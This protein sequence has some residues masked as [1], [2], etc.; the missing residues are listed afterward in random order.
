MKLTITFILIIFACS[1]LMS[2]ENFEQPDKLSLQDTVNLKNSTIL[3]TAPSN[4]ASRFEQFIKKENGTPLIMSTIETIC[5]PQSEKLDQLLKHPDQ[6]DYVVLPSRKAIQCFMEELKRNKVGGKRFTSLKYCAIG[7]DIDY[8]KKQYDK[9]VAFIPEEPSPS[10]I[11]ESLSKIKN[12]DQKTIAVIAPKVMGITEPNTI[13]RFLENLDTLGSNV[14]K[15][16]GYITRATDSSKYPEKLKQIRQGE[17]DVI[18]FTS[19]AEI[20]ALIKMLDEVHWLNQNTIA[21]FGPY[22]AANAKELGV[23]V[24]FTG[25][26]FHS[27]EEFVDGIKKFLYK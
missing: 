22:T 5:N 25:R 8:L 4:Y 17:I 14:I 2:S 12:I 15:V 18:A 7:K 23:E 19:T 10:G 13:P 9:E 21:C 26:N 16:E 11:T 27:F 6:Y 1:Q 20:E 3:V 24:D